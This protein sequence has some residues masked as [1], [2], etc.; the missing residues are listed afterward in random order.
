AAQ[1]TVN[2][3]RQLLRKTGLKAAP[4]V[5]VVA[6]A[7]FI[8]YPSIAALVDE[9]R[10]L[11]LKWYFFAI[12]LLELTRVFVERICHGTNMMKISASLSGWSAISV[13]L[14][15]VPTV[16]FSPT[17]ATVVAAKAAGM[18][19]PSARAIYSIYK[20]LTNTGDNNAVDP[21]S[22]PRVREL[23]TYGLTLAMISLADFGFIQTDIILLSY[24]TDSASAAVYS[25]GVLLVMK[26]TSISRALG[27]GVS[28]QYAKADCPPEERLRLYQNALKYVLVF[29]FPFAFFIGAFASETL[30][31]L[32]GDKYADGGTT[33]ALM[34]LFLV[35]ATVLAISSPVLDFGGKARIRAIAA[36]SG[37][38]INIGLNLL[39]IPKYGAVGAALATLCG[40]F[41]LFLVTLIAVRLMLG[42]KLLDD[43]ALRRLIVIVAPF[44][45]LLVTA[46][47]FASSHGFWICMPAMALLYPLAIVKL[48]IVEKA[49]VDRVMSF[50]KK[51]K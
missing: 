41:V 9:P 39:W 25:V 48:G 4:L 2:H 45:A 27:F 33:L 40:Y 37:A 50:I 26:L 17:A 30:N 15:T 35:M 11:E 46:C 36:F 23:A 29:C 13:L 34:C 12:L 20:A 8:A 6:L 38:A 10:L 31:L 44:L 19:I 14:I 16:W 47:K 3:Q 24:L 32:F 1:P 18:L 42:N 7:V 43:R 21:T 28:P 51:K 5:G 49:E 22:L